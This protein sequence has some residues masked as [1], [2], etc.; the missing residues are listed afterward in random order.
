[1]RSRPGRGAAAQKLGRTYQASLLHKLPKG[2][3]HMPLEERRRII[4]L[5]PNSAAIPSREH[6]AN[7]RSI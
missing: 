4:R 2:L 6:A 5:K 1:M 3:A 7:S